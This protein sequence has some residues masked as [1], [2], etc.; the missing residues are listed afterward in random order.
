MDR[1]ILAVR[2]QGWGWAPTVGL[3]Q[4]LAEIE[5]GLRASSI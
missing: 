3:P 2:A 5:E 4:A 1:R